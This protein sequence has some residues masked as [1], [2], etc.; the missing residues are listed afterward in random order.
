MLLV[1]VLVV[2]CIAAIEIFDAVFYKEANEAQRRML[3]SVVV[4]IAT[5][6][7]IGMIGF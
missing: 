6:V 3:E 2:V 5:S 1:F 4:M 7:C